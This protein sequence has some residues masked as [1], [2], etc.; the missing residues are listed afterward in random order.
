M[1]AEKTFE[2]KIKRFLTSRGCWHVKF[3]ANG[4]TKSGIPDI[5]ACVNGYFVGIEVKGP[6]GRPS[7]LQL[8]NLSKIRESGGIA[9]ILY[10]DQF[11]DF[12]MLVNDL[13][14][15]PQSLDWNEQRSFD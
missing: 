12:K 10:P 15:R 2:E 11:E 13:I 3:F 14:E 9:V 5:L 1:A 7:E 6:D 8:W 4:F